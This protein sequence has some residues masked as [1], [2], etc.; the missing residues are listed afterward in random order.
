MTRNLRRRAAIVLILVL[1]AANLLVM[2]A[3]YSVGKQ[4]WLQFVTRAAG[5]GATPDG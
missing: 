5:V 4:G 2:G 1:V 3:T